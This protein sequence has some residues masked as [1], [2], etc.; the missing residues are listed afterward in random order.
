V[1]LPVVFA[2]GGGAVK[3]FSVEAEKGTVREL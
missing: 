2:P 1:K 3:R